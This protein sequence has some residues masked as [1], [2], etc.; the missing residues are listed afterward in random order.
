MSIESRIDIVVKNL[1]QLNKLADN[2]KNINKTNEKLVKGLDRIESQL[3]K[4][5]TNGVAFKKI[6]KDA[7]DA[8]KEVNNL[9]SRIADIISNNKGG[10][11]N[12]GLGML[13]AGAIS[14]ITKIT[15]GFKNLV[16]AVN[17]VTSK[18]PV[19]GEKLQIVQQQ[20]TGFDAVFDGILHGIASHPGLWGAAAVAITAFGG[21]LPVVAKGAKLLWNGLN[22]V[23]QAVTNNI[24]GKLV[25][26][27]KHL[28]D[29][30]V[31][32]VDV[33]EQMEN[34]TRGASLEELNIMVGMAR[35]E[36]ESFWHMT[37]K[38][39]DAAIKLAV[40]MA[41]Q[42]KE[43]T[44]I[45]DLL[46]KAQGKAT[47]AEQADN[48]R[49]LDAQKQ[50]A[51]H[52]FDMFS[53]EAKQ[54]EIIQRKNKLFVESAR[55]YTRLVEKGGK[56]LDIEE[57]IKR[58]MD[59]K[60]RGFGG[61]GKGGKGAE[62]LMLGAGF[63]LLFGGGVG[64][65]AGGVGGALLGNMTGAGGFG[66]QILGSAIGTMMDTAIQ[67]AAK[68]GESLKSINMN[69]LVESGVRLSGE[70]QSQV[71]H[72]Q[73]IGQIEQARALLAAQ[74]M[75][76]TGASAGVLG[77]INNMTNILKATW[78]DLVGAVGAFLGVLTGPLVTALAGVL[79]IVTE[80]LKLF[81]RGISAIREWAR[82]VAERFAPGLVE[83]ID[84]AMDKLNAGLQEALGKADQLARKLDLDAD[85]LM[86]KRTLREGITSGGSF[87]AQ[88]RNAEI[89]K[90]MSMV[91]LGVQRRAE[92]EKLD[93]KTGSTAHKEFKGVTREMQ[94]DI[95]GTYAKEL[96]NIDAK[97][98]KLIAKLERQ[99]E[100]KAALL[101]ID[102]KIAQARSDEDKELE[103]RLNAQKEIASITSKLME[104]TAGKDDAEK[105]L[106]IQAA[107]L[108]ITKVNFALETKID[109]FRKEKKK[110]AE[111]VLADL[112]KQNDLLQGKIDGNEDE[113][114]QQQTI[115]KILDK[116][117]IKYKDQV[118][119]LVEKNGELTKEAENAKKLDEQW[120][121]IKETIA[122]GL[123]DAIMGLIDG[124]KSLSESI[125]GVAKQI[126]SMMLQK[127]IM[128]LP[129]L[130]AEGA[131]APGG[132]KAFASGGMATRPTL[133]LV[134]EAGEDEY[135]IPASKMAA[136][137]QRYSAGARGE[138]VI[139]G[140][141]S[142]YAG[143]GAG[144]STTV[145]YSGPILNFNSEEFVPKSA[146]GEII[147]TA[148]SRGAR[149]GEARALSSLQNSRSR[150]S[151][152]GL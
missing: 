92:L 132:F 21:K 103:F 29:M 14:G 31:A 138:S 13:G 15:D 50:K 86:T 56:L 74:V 121:K 126:A 137:M 47:T 110:E 1:N 3:N 19:L 18:I 106:K 11:G 6:S 122:S 53:T 113:I 127:A 45:N 76:Q 26:A 57:R 67:K 46:F 115:E 68:L 91:D 63:P 128:G 96:E 8:S 48:K 97:E 108:D 62:N 150:R 38:A 7:R 135:I 149:A 133:G 43:Q 140:T 107:K 114:K 58:V 139:P 129:F 144:G 117:G 81:N 102:Q 95:E 78:N 4:I 61:V 54:L 151:N 152:I 134:G 41:A 87:E 36:M 93:L 70:L 101:G 89:Q 66:M 142:S 112:Q 118:T 125:A 90:S 82:A 146:V 99:N 71:T 109:E 32:L 30:R 147:A 69:D 79:K 105:E 124:T 120:K 104:D 10:I 75:D 119:T 23:G 88:R 24:V 100:L 39:E 44:A 5:N 20:A 9:G 111:D 83:A 94:R 40:A 59:R 42:R 73:K 130:A 2:L 145:N 16:P 35:K 72:L 27:T 148:T 37:G 141:G 143:G 77:D 17:A 12:F 28:V 49:A 84:N 116:I 80:I 123:T 52:S 22:G 51:T 65:V 98:Q 33:R 34:M 85:T 55:H 131:Y 60:K 136:S 64:S 25:P